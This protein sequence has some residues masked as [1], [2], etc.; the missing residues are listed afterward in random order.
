MPVTFVQPSS[1]N[2]N[3]LG[4][5]CFAYSTL[6]ALASNHVPLP[7]IAN[8]L[9]A[10]T[11]IGAQKTFVSMGGGPGTV[12]KALNLTPPEYAV[13]FSDNLFARANYAVQ[14]HLPAVLATTVGGSNHWIFLTGVV[15]AQ[16]GAT[17]P[18]PRQ[19][20]GEDQQNPN[21]GVLSFQ[22]DGAQFKATYT[23]PTNTVVTYTLNSISVFIT[24]TLQRD[25]LTAAK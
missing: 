9:Q 12:L 24:T 8:Q 15:P 14:N 17:P 23:T 10:D 4:T 11:W 7:N 25:G 6:N 3:T 22:Y 18:V 16:P 1:A 13:Q 5:K 21:R 20:L 19:I 2:G